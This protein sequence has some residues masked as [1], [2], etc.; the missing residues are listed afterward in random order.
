MA[1]LHVCFHKF[2]G[3]ASGR[4]AGAQVPLPLVLPWSPLGAPVPFFRRNKKEEDRKWERKK[5]SEEPLLRDEEEG[6]RVPST[7]YVVVW[8]D[9]LCDRRHLFARSRALG[10]CLLSVY[11][12]NIIRMLII[13]SL[14]QTY[15]LRIEIFVAIDFFSQLWAFVLFKHYASII[16]FACY[17]LYYC[18]YFK[19][20]LSFY[21]FAIIFFE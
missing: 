7:A 19:L 15:S 8:L 21:T 3:L 2:N 17:I 13:R 4:V 10:L 11:W 18:R 5:E 16:Y 12:V 9:A 20:D 6:G 1:G 14:D